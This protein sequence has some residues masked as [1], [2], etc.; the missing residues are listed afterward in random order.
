MRALII[1]KTGQVALALQDVMPQ[2]GFDVQTF[3]R[4]EL[5]LQNLET[6]PSLV[7]EIAPNIIINA[8]AYTAVEKAED[9]QE[10]AFAINANAPEMLA[11]LCA[12]HNIPLIHYS[13]D[14]VFDGTK[15]EP[16]VEN[17]AVNPL[18]IYG[19]SK[20]KGEQ[21]IAAHLP[22]H[23]ILRTSWVCS[24]N[25]TNFMNT[26]LKLAQTRSE[27][28]VVEDQFGAPTF[29]HDIAQATA[30]IALQLLKS[31]ENIAQYGIY[32]LANVGETNWAEFAR[33]IFANASLPV[34]VHGIA[35]A[36]YPT[37]AKRPQN[38][39]QNCEKLQRVFG[40]EMPTWQEALKRDMKVQ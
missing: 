29:A 15:L 6:L 4:P 38:S 5:D 19:M 16:Y 34:T 14:Y 36:Q 24:P 39:R 11:K 26:M 22:Q 32:H 30:K 31:P 33:A 28:N 27:L 8:A 40:V 25:G 35:A 3:G 37:K 10:A 12:Q 2:H 13:T 7:V 20:L 17:D 1:G 21:N 9:E 18:N 23:V